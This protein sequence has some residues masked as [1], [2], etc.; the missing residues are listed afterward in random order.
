[1]EIERAGG[2]LYV[3]IQPNIEVRADKVHLNN[4]IHSLLDNAKKYAKEYPHVTIELSKKNKAAILT[5]KD[6][7]KGIPKAY[8]DKIFNKF[9]RV[10]TGNLHDVKGFGLGLFYV[11]N[12]CKAHHW[13]YQLSSEEG[14]GTTFSIKI[15]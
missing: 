1:M 8:Q 11:R 15:K 4:I 7:G 14:V 13:K 10:P 12:I 2:S 9:F 6:Q 3:E 5:I